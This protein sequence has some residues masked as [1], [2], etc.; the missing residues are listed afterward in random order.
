MKKKYLFMSS[1]FVIG[2]IFT[3][4]FFWSYKVY[5]KSTQ[6]VPVEEEAADTVD[7]VAEPRT[8]A[9]MKYVLETYDDTTGV[10]TSEEA[11]VPEE[12]AGLTREELEDLFSQYN[13]S[14]A[15]GGVADGPDSKELISF[16]KD[17]IVV[18]ETYSGAEEEEGFFLKSENG[19]VVI[20][21]RDQ[22]TPYENTGI[23]S[24]V[25]PEDEQEKLREGFFVADEKELYS[26]LE[27]LSS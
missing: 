23:Q 24:D 8:N 15:E 18:R 9:S 13:Q 22:V 16:S 27:N 12:L 20:F 7:T 5:D 1:F 2:T 19:E 17:R 10:V 14:V 6:E 3:L 21:H 25:L 26:I 11:E 4:M